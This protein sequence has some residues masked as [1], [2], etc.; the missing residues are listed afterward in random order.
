MEKA[1]I[2]SPPSL[3]SDRYGLEERRGGKNGMV[4][5]LEGRVTMKAATV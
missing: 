2:F 4:A 1:I 5:D 3:M